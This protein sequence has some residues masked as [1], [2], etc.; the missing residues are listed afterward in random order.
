M[1]PTRYSVL[2][3]ENNLSD[4]DFQRLTNNICWSYAR[5]TRA[6]SLGIAYS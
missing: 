4:D 5:A 3:D 6:V 2:L 1:Q